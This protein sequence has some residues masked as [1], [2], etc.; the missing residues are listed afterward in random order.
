MQLRPSHAVEMQGHHNAEIIGGSVTG[1]RS[2]ASAGRYPG[3]KWHR[4]QPVRPA[5]TTRSRN[6]CVMSTRNGRPRGSLKMG[7]NSAR[8]VVIHQAHRR[9]RPLIRHRQPAKAVDPEV[10]VLIMDRF[11]PP[12]LVHFRP[13]SYTRVIASSSLGVSRYSLTLGWPWRRRLVEPFATACHA[14][15]AWT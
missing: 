6:C 3:V 5:S 13:S 12:E 10:L 7:G 1:D 9:A 15:P 14:A 11:Q 8:N 2:S 4:V